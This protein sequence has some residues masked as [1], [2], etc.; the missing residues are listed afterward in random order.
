MR[1]AFAP[2]GTSDVRAMITM[3]AAC[4]TM[5]TL[6]ACGAPSGSQAN[7][8]EPSPIAR[9]HKAKCGSCH[10]RVEP[11]QRTRAQLE[12]A[13]T[14]HHKRVRLTEEQWAQMVDYLAARGDAGAD[15]SP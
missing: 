14:R 1:S 10:V 5:A 4:A 15:A 6:F 8:P 3:A 11:G 7:A 2:K 9:I 12:D 13:F